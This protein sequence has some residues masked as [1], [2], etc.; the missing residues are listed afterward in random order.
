M[1]EAWTRTNRMDSA[2]IFVTAADPQNG[3]KLPL[4]ATRTGVRDLPARLILWCAWLAVVVLLATG[5]VMWRDEV[6]ALSIAMHGDTIFAML[7]SL[8]GEGHPALWYLMLRGAHTLVPVPQILPVLAF[9]VGASAMLVFT[10]RSPFPLPIVFLVLFSGFGLF[11]YTVSARNY[12]ISM[13]I[14][15]VLAH[16]FSRRKT[17]LPLP[18]FLIFLLCN[19]NVH[20]IFFAAGFM[21]F[22]LMELISEGGIQAILRSRPFLAA[23]A[24]SAIGV[25]ACV[26]TVYPPIN[27]AAQIAHGDGIGITVLISALSTPGSAFLQ[28]APPGVE[29]AIWPVA[30]TILIL[31]S[32]TSL[33]RAPGTLAGGVFVLLGLQLFFRL[34]YPGE[35]RHVA[36]FPVFIVTMAWLARIGRGGAWPAAF[37]L[38]APRVQLLERVG[39][40]FLALL[41]LLQLPMGMNAVRD[42]L[43]GREKSSSRDLAMLLEQPALR[44]A[45]IVAD[46]DYLVEALPYY[47]D[48]PTYFLREHRYGK[49]VVFSK[50]AQLDLTLSQIL[51]TARK[52]H[53]ENAR[54]VVILLQHRIDPAVLPR[55]YA[56]GY[57]W[58]FSVTS[59]DARQFLAAT[60]RIA[61]LDK[62]TGDEVFDV[63]QLKTSAATSSPGQLL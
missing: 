57:N 31:G 30:I 42:S 33:I 50:K 51:A 36:M 34:I 24:C 59:A 17:G 2:A 14:L 21:L 13:L 5:H 26:A 4:D 27:D 22:W 11:E 29:A 32:L 35:Y 52:I 54:P 12:G 45:T 10:L 6:R 61:R 39:L 20:S 19:S 23:T 58:T 60:R 48:N 7:R 38:T 16:C 62:A 40:A 44:N 53:E 46:P 28:L 18:A 37:G 63:Y 55:V 8:H 43:A 25:L 49:V 15:F 56:E 9:A 1:A 3:L 47:A 41:L